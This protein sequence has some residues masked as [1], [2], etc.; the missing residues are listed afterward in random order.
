MENTSVLHFGMGEKS[1]FVAIALLQSLNMPQEVL[2][3]IG[4]GLTINGLNIGTPDKVFR[5][6]QD[7]TE[8]RIQAPGQDVIVISAVCDVPERTAEEMAEINANRSGENQEAQAEVV[9]APEE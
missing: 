6:P 8:L 7:T 9:E 4:N 2:N 3:G 5:L 1:R